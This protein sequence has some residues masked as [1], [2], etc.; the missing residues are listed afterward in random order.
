MVRGRNSS[1]VKFI[2]SSDRIPTGVG[3]IARS[4]I[5]EFK[6]YFNIIILTDKK[7]IANGI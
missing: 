3:P 2:R 5:P 4:Q 7:L 6:R 1:F